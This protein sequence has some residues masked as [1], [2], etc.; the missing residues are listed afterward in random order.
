MNRFENIIDNLTE[1]ATTSGKFHALIVVGSQARKV[2]KADEHSD[3]DIII[4]VDDPNYFIISDEWIKNI[5]VHYVSFS[6]YSIGGGKERRILFDKALDVDFIFL[7]K[8]AIKESFEDNVIVD[9]LKRGYRILVDNIGL[10]SLLPQ[11]Q[12]INQV[13]SI[14]SKQ[15]FQNLTND[16]WYHSVWAAK[17]IIR[18]EIWTAKYCVDTYMKSKLLSIIECRARIVNGLEYDTWHNGRFIEQWA[19]DWIITELQNCFSHYNK[20]DIKCALLSTMDLFRTIAA[21]VAKK[22]GY[23]YPKTADEY[24]TDWVKANL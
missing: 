8:N 16:F 6:D 11:N 5:G 17:K 13:Y 12:E 24:A 2:Q 20:E 21:E 3:L 10:E 15:E 23:D 4:I 22:G 7:P 1:S 19:D 9:I 18:G 14:L